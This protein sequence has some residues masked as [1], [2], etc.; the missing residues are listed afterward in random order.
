MNTDV[1]ARARRAQIGAL[2]GRAALAVALCAAG[3]LASACEGPRAVATGE[4]ARAFSLPPLANSGHDISLSNYAGR[5]VIIVFFATWSPTSAAE[6]RVLGHFYRSRHGRVLIVGVDARDSPDAARQL[7]RKM[8]V[9]YPVAA[10]GSLAVATR[11]HVPGVPAAYFL[12]ARHKIVVT[13]LGGLNWAK[14]KQGVTAMRTSTV[15][16]HPNGE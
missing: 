15:I 11:F 14:I 7:L 9:T 13:Q 5:P 3:F 6:I 10:D 4:Q 8:R 12:D 16:R 1:H 2:G